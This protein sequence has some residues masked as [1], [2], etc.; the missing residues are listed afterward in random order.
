MQKFFII[1]K[2]YDHAVDRKERVY[3]NNQFLKPN[4]EMWSS[5]VL[6]SYFC[7]VLNLLSIFSMELLQFKM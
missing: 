1:R 7:F 6:Q 3:M 4:E 5:E 2:K